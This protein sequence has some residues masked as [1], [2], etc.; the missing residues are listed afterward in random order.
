MS[1]NAYDVSAGLFIRGLTNLK[2]QLTKAEA[3]A[4]AGGIGEAALLNASLAA[5]G[6]EHRGTV[7]APFD[8][9][10]YTLAAQ[11]HWAAE[12]SRLAIAQVLGEPR[13]PTANDAKSFAD[14][15][16][17]IDAT[18][19]YLRGI[20]PAD[21]EAVVDRAIVVEHRRGPLSSTGAQFLI[22]FAIPH[23]FY[24]ATSAYA[25]LRNQGVQLTMGDNLGNW[26]T[27]IH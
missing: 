22:A 5:S 16:H 20:T 11:V 23:F 2:A 25:I 12:G 9:H 21:L 6:A 26:A 17:R 3:H 1:L 18:I 24:H 27:G 8:L 19:A 10:A 14:L 4:A 13:V 15:H 7:A